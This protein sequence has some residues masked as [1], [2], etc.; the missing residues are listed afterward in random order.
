[1]HRSNFSH[2]RKLI[3]ISSFVTFAALFQTGCQDQGV[4][5]PNTS[6][7][8]PV[9]VLS[10]L[11]DSDIAHH[12]NNAL[13]YYYDNY[14]VSSSSMVETSGGIAYLKQTS[15]NDIFTAMKAYG[16]AEGWTATE[17]QDAVDI[18]KNTLATANFYHQV[19]GVTCLKDFRTN[20]SDIF[21]AAVSLQ[22]V[23]QATINAIQHVF[24]AAAN[25]S[26]MAHVKTLINLL[27]PS[28][29][30][31]AQT[32]RNIEI[33]KAVADSSYAF[34]NDPNNVVK[35][36][37]APVALRR[38]SWVLV[39]DA[40]GAVIGSIFMGGFGSIICGAYA[41]IHLNETL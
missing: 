2:I 40:A 38:D 14:H 37:G 33:F 5:H 10:Y 31:A 28:A 1:M 26:S 29:Y 18:M 30:P 8:K 4:S 35:T 19:N 17:S 20:Y 32:Q 41:S 15:S 11:S 25:D 21:T 34:W 7:S 22:Y 12:H 27:Q 39:G 3:T 36:G 24:T 23:D 6:L 9:D 13:H 16:I